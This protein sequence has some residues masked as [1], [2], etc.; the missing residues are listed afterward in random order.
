MSS[1][2]NPFDESTGVLIQCA[3]PNMQ[4]AYRGRDALIS[5]DHGFVPREGRAFKKCDGKYIY[6]SMKT[7]CR[8]RSSA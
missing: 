3:M 8:S 5:G 6:S 4:G 1:E 7:H 2:K